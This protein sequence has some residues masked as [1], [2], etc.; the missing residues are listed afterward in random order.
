M[1]TKWD[2][3]ILVVIKWVWMWYQ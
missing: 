1:G 2:G 3:A